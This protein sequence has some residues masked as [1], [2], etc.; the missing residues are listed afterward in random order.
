MIWIALGEVVKT[1]P[2][3]KEKLD[4]LHQSFTASGFYGTLEV[5]Y[6]GGKIFQVVVHE[7]I[8]L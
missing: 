5:K 1:E 2:T 7:S 3:P 4:L 6:Q 8:Q